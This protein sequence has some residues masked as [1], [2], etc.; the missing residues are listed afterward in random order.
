MYNAVAEQGVALRS[1]PNAYE[2][3]CAVCTLT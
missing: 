2:M 3:A 1:P